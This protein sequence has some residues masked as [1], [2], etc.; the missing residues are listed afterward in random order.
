[1][2]RAVGRYTGV[3]EICMLCVVDDMYVCVDVETASSS[4]VPLEVERRAKE[5]VPGVSHT[6][7]PPRPPP[8]KRSV[9]V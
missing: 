2:N 6:P 9:C 7:P 5:E 8:T 1:M 4:S 3:I